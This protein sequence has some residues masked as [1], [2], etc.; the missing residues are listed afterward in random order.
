[1]CLITCQQ[2]NNKIYQLLFIE[3]LKIEITVCKAHEKE[4][5]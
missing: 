1:M 3:C 4:R 5:Y 2:Y